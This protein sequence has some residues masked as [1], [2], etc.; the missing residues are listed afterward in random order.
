M[1]TTTVIPAAAAPGRSERKPITRERILQNYIKL[2][3]L[4]APEVKTAKDA[5]EFTSVLFLAL[6]AFSGAVVPFLLPGV[7]FYF[8]AKKGGRHE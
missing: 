1:K 7:L 4:V 3:R 8:L 5:Y 2:I 6:F